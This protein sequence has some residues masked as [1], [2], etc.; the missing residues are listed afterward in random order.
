VEIL[1]SFN[2]ED[3]YLAEALQASLFM[4]EPDQQ[5]VLSPASYGAVLFKENIAN[6]VYEAD[7]FVLVAGP[8]GISRWQETELEVALQRKSYEAHFPV[9]PVLAGKAEVPGIL[10]PYDLKWMKLPVVTDRTML[11][12]LLDEIKGS[13]AAS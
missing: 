1:I 12:R 13:S 11:A 6:G 8:N 3:V 5:T 10:V 2:L 4:L 9:V 7:A